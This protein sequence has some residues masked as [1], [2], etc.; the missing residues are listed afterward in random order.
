M[1]LSIV[2]VL[3]F[4]IVAIVTVVSSDWFLKKCSIL[5]FFCVSLIFTLIWFLLILGVNI[6]L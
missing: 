6:L 2:F 4:I 5:G 3:L 1:V